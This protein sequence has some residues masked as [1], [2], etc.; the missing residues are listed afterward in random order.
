M[1]IS[2]AEGWIDISHLQSSRLMW[3]GS[4][5]VR[6]LTRDLDPTRRAPRTEDLQILQYLSVPEALGDV[7]MG[8][9]IGRSDVPDSSI[10]SGGDLQVLLET[11]HSTNGTGL[12]SLVTSRS[13]GIE[14]RFQNL[15]SEIVIRSIAVWVVSGFLNTVS[16]ASQNTRHRKL[17]LP[18]STPPVV[19]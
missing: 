13:P 14:V 18:R 2:V 16:A 8:N 11:F 1:F 5:N 19:Q 9:I 4:S 17:G 12:I 15:G 7:D 6:Y 10:S 3:F